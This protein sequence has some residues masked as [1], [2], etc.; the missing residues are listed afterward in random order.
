LQGTVRELKK[1][2]N[3]LGRNALIH[4]PFRFFKF[5]RRGVDEQA[6]NRVL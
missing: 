2:P 4:C 6:G 3:N 1:A 5:H